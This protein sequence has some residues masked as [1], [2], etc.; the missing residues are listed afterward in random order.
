[1]AN[2][3]KDC[4][5]LDDLTRFATDCQ[6]AE[7]L[8]DL[9]GTIDAAVRDLGFRWFTLLHNIDLRRGDEQS[10]FLTTYPSAWLEEVLEERHYLEDPIHRSEERR[11]GQECL[12]TCRSRWS[13]YH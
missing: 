4:G 1:M 11:V 2:R 7:T 5:R 8:G 9:H 10:L 12:S 13:R 6:R 3:I